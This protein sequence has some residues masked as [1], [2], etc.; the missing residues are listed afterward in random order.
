MALQTNQIKREITSLSAAEQW[1]ED[2]PHR[3]AEN[4]TGV[5]VSDEVHAAYGKNPSRLFDN[6]K[7]KDK[8]SPKRA[9]ASKAS[10]A[11]TYTRVSSGQIRFSASVDQYNK[12]IAN[13]EKRLRNKELNKL[14][15]FGDRSRQTVVKMIRELRD[16]N[17]E[18]LTISTS[19][20]TAMGWILEDTL[21]GLKHG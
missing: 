3:K 5:T 10:T 13:F 12:D 8:Q 17:L 7:S 1:L 6:D 2:N 14:G 16:R 15:D 21:E 19:N 18:V 11:K 9:H 4:M 20:K